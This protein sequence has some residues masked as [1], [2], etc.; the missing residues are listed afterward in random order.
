MSE[1]TLAHKLMLKSGR[2]LLVNAPAGYAERLG[3]L[4]EGL[5]LVAASAEQVEAIQVFVA[6][7]AE[8]EAEIPRL[9][10]LLAP[11]G[12]LWISYHKGTSSVK[13][14]INR[15]SIWAYARTVGLD[16]VAQ[17]AIDE[18]WSAIR[19]KVV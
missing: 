11:R 10:P 17:V 12:M 2:L 5:T 19:L 18:D 15:D 8:L 6:N 7:R 13:T 1:K 14:D 4:P 3:P 9:R 16:A